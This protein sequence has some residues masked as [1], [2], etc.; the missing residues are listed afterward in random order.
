MELGRSYSSGWAAGQLG[1]SLPTQN[2]FFYSCGRV[3]W[4]W[5]I[6]AATLAILTLTVTLTVRGP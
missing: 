6:G 5:H 1:G 4:L 2:S 3:L